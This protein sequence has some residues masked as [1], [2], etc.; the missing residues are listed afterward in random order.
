MK[1]ESI[2]RTAIC[3]LA[4]S[5]RKNERVRENI[6]QWQT[7]ARRMA[8]LM[9]SMPPYRWGAGTTDTHLYR[10]TVREHDALGL[11]LYAANAHEAA[12]KVG[13]AFSSWREN[14]QRG[15]RPIGRFGDGDYARYRADY[16]E[17]VENDRGWGVKFKL[18]PR[19]P[20]EWFQIIDGPYQREYLSAVSAGE[21][22]TGSAELHL[23][24][25]GSLFCHLTVKRE[26]EVLTDDDV[27]RWVGVDLGERVIYAAAAVD[28]AGDGDVAVDVEPGREFRH[29]RERLKRHR[30]ELSKA[31]DIRAVRATRDL[32]RYTD[33]M[34]HVTARQIIDFALEQ[35]AGGIRVENLT[36][37][38]SRA[39]W[40]D[41]DYIHDWPHHELRDKIKAKAT[42]SGL[43]F[44][45]ILP[46]GTSIT[47]RKCGQEDTAARNGLQ[48]SCRRCGYEVHADVNAA[49]NIA[50]GGVE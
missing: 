36:G 43:E 3:K 21:A 1:T 49:I 11:N 48:F 6:D 4:T 16:L 22:S 7:L 40:D 42:E 31:G 37:W 23:H 20:A 34:T 38:R 50:R 45:Q 19:T 9:P 25:D 29:H 44:E 30:Y 39:V 17:V 10:M 15:I 2:T 18:I 14:G 12:K 26:I 28:E 32:R 5:N 13:E 35:E 27:T 46:A 24:A 33:Q 41:D 47:C 8:E